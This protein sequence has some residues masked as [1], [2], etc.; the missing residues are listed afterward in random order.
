MNKLL[1]VILFVASTCFALDVVGESPSFNY[2]GEPNPGYFRLDNKG[3]GEIKGV[4]VYYYIDV[5]YIKDYAPYYSKKPFLMD[6]SVKVPGGF[7]LWG[8]KIAYKFR[9]VF[10]LVKETIP[11]GGVYPDNG[12]YLKWMYK[13]IDNHIVAKYFG[14]QKKQLS[15]LKLE[16]FVVESTYGKV[17]YGKHPENN[18][19]IGILK[20]EGCSTPAWAEITLDVEN[21]NNNTRLV[22]GAQDPPGFTFGG[23]VKFGVC[24]VSYESIPR[25]PF[26]YVVFRGDEHCPKG[27]YAFRRRHDTEDSDNRN[28][29]DGNVDI[30][31]SVVG[32]NASLEYC[33]VPADSKSKLDF[34]FKNNYDVYTSGFG[35]FANIDTENIAHSEVYIDDEDSDNNNKWEFY[36]AS[37]DIQKRI[38]KIVDG[39]HNTTYHFAKWRGYGTDNWYAE[40][41]ERERGGLAKEGTV[42]EPGK[43][44]LKEKAFSPKIKGVDRSSIFVELKSAG[45]VKISVVNVNGA[46]VANVVQES[47][48]PGV[49]Q[50]KWNSGVEPKGRYVVKVQQNG[51]VDAKNV[52]LK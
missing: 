38:R 17:L 25:V 27:T 19:R 30:W 20:H 23:R 12:N 42:D 3:G 18:K 36:G 1:L 51:M 2:Y 14:L 41:L 21:S 37:E 39:S 26:D 50:I 11:A 34:P 8:E 47:L 33:F 35:V 31:P 6:G 15:D 4:K 28:S 32:E 45:N 44:V 13:R 48:E 22:R 40:M 16:N 7:N 24:F 49:H 46:V 9:I 10:N 52:V 43:Y 5:D 29:V